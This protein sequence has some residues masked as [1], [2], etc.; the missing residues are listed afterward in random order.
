MFQKILVLA[1]NYKLIDFLLRY[2]P[3]VFPLSEYHVLSTIDFGYDIISVTPYVEDTLED[4]ALR[5]MLHCASVLEEAGIHSRKTIKK[6]NFQAIVDKYVRE[7][8]IDLVAIETY[9]DEEKKKSHFSEHLE[10]LF[11]AVKIPILFMDRPADLKKP[12][13][14]CILYSGTG[15]SEEAASLGMRFSKWLGASCTILYVG[16]LKSSQV[17]PHLERK[18]EKI[19][20]RVEIDFVGHTSARELAE[21]IGS[22]DLFVTSRGGQS[23]KDRVIMAIKRLPLKNIEIGAIMY[24]PIPTILVGETPGVSHGY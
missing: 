16:R 8:E 19:G 9:I 2:T 7:N 22:H 24:A 18:A 15:H 6:G 10:G 5:A 13:S 11:R 23:W 14:V 3:R 4:S 17:F 1:D 12:E 20:V 21:T